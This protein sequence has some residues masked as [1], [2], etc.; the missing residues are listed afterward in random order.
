MSG[1]LHSLVNFL[2]GERDPM[3]PK[4]GLESQSEHEQGGEENSFCIT[5]LQVKT[6]S[7][8]LLYQTPTTLNP[9][10]KLTS[11]NAILIGG[12]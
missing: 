10:Q 8:V 11:Q 7:Q 12:L 5:L 9:T 3:H 1:Q 6:T 2:R 4:G